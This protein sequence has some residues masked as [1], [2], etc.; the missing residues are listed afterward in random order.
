MLDRR[1]FL[2][3][4]SASLPLL[5]VPGSLCAQG[6]A[7]RLHAM[8][9]GINTYTGRGGDGR[10]IRSLRGCQ[11]DA[12]DIWE[13][14]KKY[15]PATLVRLGW[16]ATARRDRTVKR[17]DFLRTWEETLAA[18]SSGDRLLLTFAGHGSRVPVLPGNPSNETDGIRRDAGAHGVRC[19]P[20]KEWRAHHRRRAG[21]DV[22]GGERQGGDRHL[23]RRQLPLWNLDPQRRRAR[24]RQELSLRCP[25]APAPARQRY[26]APHDARRT[27]P[28]AAESGVHRRLAGGRD[29]ARDRRSPHPPAARRP[30]HRGGT[31]TGGRGRRR[32]HHH[33][34]QPDHLRPASRPAGGAGRPE[35]R[36]RS[37]PRWSPR[38]SSIATRSCSCCQ[39]EPPPVA[40]GIQPLRLRIHGRSAADAQRLIDTLRNAALA[41]SGEAETLAWHA[42]RRLILND[43]G[44]RVAENVGERDLQGVV[45][46][47]LAL[48]RLIQMAANGLDVQ[49]LIDGQDTPASDA[50]RKPGDRLAVKVSG[51]ASGD[52]LAVFN[53]AG[54]GLVEMLE[55][56]PYHE[57]NPHRA[58]FKRPNFITGTPIHSSEKA[59]PNVHV[60]EPF[61]ADHVVAVAGARP[62]SRLD[63]GS[64]GGAQAARGSRGDGRVGERAPGPAAEDRAAR[65]LHLAVVGGSRTGADGPLPFA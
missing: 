9:V 17:A 52:Y 21:R 29:G 37:G 48:D 18:A 32:R 6:A 36:H 13:Q 24:R 12:A 43:Q 58:D 50:T 42:D 15:Q 34:P 35:H 44:H 4:L 31:G 33:H 20:G 61:G 27:R 22:P 56:T 53:F 63:G 54:N 38:A 26:P 11:N 64:G 30:Q 10:P 40:P 65:H 51:L 46:C 14:V 1:T 5:A 7:P 60:G 8:I 45:D 62:L 23:H 59:L 25:S 19:Q 57:P 2:G 39:A 41:G 49:V 47:R 55:P 3:G 28:D 16:D